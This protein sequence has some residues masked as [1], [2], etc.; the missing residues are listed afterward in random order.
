MSAVPN[1]TGRKATFRLDQYPAVEELAHALGTELR[2]HIMQLVGERPLSVA[3]LAEKLGV[4]V[5]TCSL[6]VQVLE[7][8]KL[9]RCER[10]PGQRGTAKICSRRLDQVTFDLRLP[11]EMK[12]EVQ[13]LEI[14]VGCYSSVGEITATCGMTD[15]VS[16]NKYFDNPACFLHPYH[17]TA[18]LI[19]MH[20]GYVEY[21]IPP[22]ENLPELRE[23]E[24]T[25]E[26][27]AEA[28][29]YCNDWP[30][31]I[32]VEVN[33]CEL[34]VWRCPGDY[35]GRRGLLNPDWWS[36]LDTQYGELKSW[37]VLQG[38]TKLNGE[39]LSSVRLEDLHLDSPAGVSIRLGVHADAKCVGGMNLFGASF[40]DHPQGIV[41]RSY[42]EPIGDKASVD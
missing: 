42:Y 35:G 28:P 40:G 25:F 22:F 3:E 1:I 11:S 21:T 41:V 7:S 32:Y 38:C 30:S 39:Y 10:L 31:D 14:P 5:S 29:S 12:K 13:A 24:I 8:A 4:P 33:G 34:G 16:L 17:F 36:D 26:A 6:N 37:R 27:C 2:L 9:L 15:H 19:W 18:G 20:S 23:L